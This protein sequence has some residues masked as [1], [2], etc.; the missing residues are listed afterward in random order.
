V[1]GGD[2]DIGFTINPPANPPFEVART[3]DITVGAIVAPGHPLAKR[4]KV[5]IADCLTYPLLRGRTPKITAVID[6]AIGARARVPNFIESN[7]SRFKTALVRKGDFVAFSPSFALEPQIADGSLVFV[8]MEGPAVTGDCF[9]VIAHRK[10][11]A[12]APARFLEF[13]CDMI[14]QHQQL[15]SP[16]PRPA[17]KRRRKP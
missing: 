10:K 4:R 12:P 5:T 1:A 2:A 7:S 14:A 3:Y 15:F 17:K 6:E 13:S 9:A 11:M 8:P 16:T